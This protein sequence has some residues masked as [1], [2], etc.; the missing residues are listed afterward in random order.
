MAKRYFASEHCYF[1]NRLLLWHPIHD[2]YSI[3]GPVLATVP[4]VAATVPA[5]AA[6]VPA[7]ATTA[8]VGR[9]SGRLD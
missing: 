8:A 6:T 3:L 9:G 1:P 5:V 7:V 2:V 4:N